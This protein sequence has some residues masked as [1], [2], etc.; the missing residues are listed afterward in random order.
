MNSSS[1]HIRGKAKWVKCPTGVIIDPCVQ[2]ISENSTSNIY[3]SPDFGL[4]V[5]G[6]DSTTKSLTLFS[7]TENVE[8]FAA[9]W[10]VGDDFFEDTP[11]SITDST[12][13]FA[14]Y[15]DYAVNDYDISFDLHQWSVD[16]GAINGDTHSFTF[17][18]RVGNGVCI[19]ELTSLTVHESIVVGVPIP[20]IPTELA[21]VSGDEQVSV[22]WEVGVLA[23]NIVMNYKVSKDSNWIELIISTISPLLLL[24][25]VNGTSYDFRIAARGVS[26]DSAFT[27]VVK[28]SPV[29][30]A[31]NSFRFTV[32]SATTGATNNDQFTITTGAGTFLY[33]V[34]TDD[35]YTATGLTGSHVITFPSGAGVHDVVITGE[36]AAMANNTSA[37]A[38][39]I[40]DISN[41]GMYG[42]NSTSQN[43]SF[44]GCSNLSISATDAARF[45]NVTNFFRMFFGDSSLTTFPNMTIGSATSF[46]NLCF[47]SGVTNF[48]ANM[49]DNT[50]ATDFARAF[51]ITNLT[52]QSIDNILISID[53]S[54][55]VNGNFKQSGGQAPSAAGIVAKDS[56]VAKGW[57]IVHTT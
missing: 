16:N 32:N 18:S 22:S 51:E 35:G 27:S 53:A 46:S 28:A 12:G 11:I 23:T 14:S 41:W 1:K 44:Q 20:S 39:K 8:L 21:I 6:S 10:A 47:I 42:E 13:F 33:D 7:N 57:T 4:T 49:F 26:G 37:D 48:P 50:S 40:D 29:A 2:Y 52:T 38:K 3:A 45:D 43:A 5:I 34:T 30:S 19:T 15:A 36:F 31:D 9:T 25:L 24:N 17:S 56:L 55:G 54:G